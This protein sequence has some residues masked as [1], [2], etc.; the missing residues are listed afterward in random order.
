M[1][2]KD[3]ESCAAC[4][5]CICPNCFHADAPIGACAWNGAEDGIVFHD[6]SSALRKA[7][8]P[9]VGAGE[10]AV[11]AARGVDEHV[12]RP[13]TWREGRVAGLYTRR[14]G[15]WPSRGAVVV[16]VHGLGLSGRYFTP[17]A[18][19]LAAAGRTVLVPDLPGS[20]RS[21][22]AVRRT[23]AVEEAAEALLR[24][25]TAAAIGPCVWV[26]NS[27]GCQTTAVLAADHPHLV[28]RMVFIGPA[29]DAT[30]L[31]P[32][33]Q[34][35]RLLADAP[36]EP[37][38]L[39]ALAAADYLVTGAG[40][41]LAMFHQA[42]QDAA[43]PFVVRLGQIE[44]PALVLR[45]SKDRVAP[46]SWAERVCTGL[47]DGRLAVVSGA[48]HAVHFSRPDTTARQILQFLQ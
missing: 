22:R 11:V 26:A 48:G 27:V 8:A 1:T 40:R 28:Q 41:F 20:A 32:A 3:D 23:P 13:V 9:A 34:L 43:G 29:L 16:L 36:R 14:F 21:R 24:W 25:Q 10:K 38:S 33:R 5:D 47:L 4:H 37:P 2:S 15:P 39:L 45:G 44:V 17:L 35:L 18:R 31:S 30:A 7:L 46:Q 12:A 6:V 42:Q 19:S